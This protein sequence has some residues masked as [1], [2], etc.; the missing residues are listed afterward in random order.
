MDAATKQPTQATIAIAQIQHK[1]NERP[2]RT[3]P[4]GYFFKI[5]DPGTYKIDVVLADGRKASGEVKMNG[6]PQAIEVSVQ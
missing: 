5:L 2:F 1:L 6:Q 4:S 3:N